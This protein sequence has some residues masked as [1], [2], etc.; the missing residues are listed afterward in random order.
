MAMYETHKTTPAG[1]S[2]TLARKLARATKYHP[3]PATAHVMHA[4]PTPYRFHPANA[5]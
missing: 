2:E 3:T 4:A 5:R 1:K